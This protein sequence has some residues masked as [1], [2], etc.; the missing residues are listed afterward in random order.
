RFFLAAAAQGNAGAHRR[1]LSQLCA[2]VDGRPRVYLARPAAADDR[3][4]LSDRLCQNR[5]IGQ[6]FSVSVVTQGEGGFA[7]RVYGPDDEESEMRHKVPLSPVAILLGLASLASP[8]DAAHC[9]ACSYPI[10]GACP[11]Q[12]SPPAVRYRICY[13]T[14][15]EERTKVCY[16]PVHR[17]VMKECRY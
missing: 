1:Q 2:G 17:T 8:A 15:T 10:Q 7:P 5:P 13:K 14:V 11:E 4:F 16:R 9:G 3:S 6:I 12:C